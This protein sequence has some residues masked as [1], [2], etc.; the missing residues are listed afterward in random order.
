MPSTQ[1]RT[2]LNRL[3]RLLAWAIAAAVLTVIYLAYLDPHVIVD[4]AT[5]FWSC[6]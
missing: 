5:R 2:W 1:G 3:P 4:L 6:F